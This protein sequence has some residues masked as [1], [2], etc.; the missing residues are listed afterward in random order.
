M[1]NFAFPK[2]KVNLFSTFQSCVNANYT[3][4][5]I[6][7]I[8]GGSS[9]GIDNGETR[10]SSISSVC[11]FNFYQ[12]P[13][14]AILNARLT[15]TLTNIVVVGATGY[16]NPNIVVNMLPEIIEMNINTNG[17]SSN[18]FEGIEPT[19]KVFPYVL[20][21]SWYKYSNGNT[22][23]LFPSHEG[24]QYI[25][26]ITWA[27]NQFTFNSTT[28]VNSN[29]KV[30]FENSIPSSRYPL[31]GCVSTNTC[32]GYVQSKLKLSITDI[33]SVAGNV[34]FAEN[35]RE[36]YRY[37]FK[38]NSNGTAGWVSGENPNPSCT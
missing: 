20:N 12:L 5:W 14:T 27:S 4:S 25:Q 21:G 10:A 37:T 18:I 24:V 1:L 30:Y 29:F 19:Y 36:L 23:C 32:S 28:N 11:N 17:S 22:C 33:T 15:I 13:T 2:V 8:P 34:S 9:V 3:N 35:Y 31:V 7:Q 6:S 26:E 38:S 16:T